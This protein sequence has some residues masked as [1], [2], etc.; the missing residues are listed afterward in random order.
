MKQLAPF[1]VTSDLLNELNTL[2]APSMLAAALRAAFTELGAAYPQHLTLAGFTGEFKEG[3]R[4]G[5]RVQLAIEEAAALA[6]ER[7]FNLYFSKGDT[8]GRVG[9][10]RL[11]FAPP[12][13]GRLLPYSISPAVA[14]GRTDR[15]L[16]R[17]TPAIATGEL[18]ADGQALLWM[19]GQ[20][21]RAYLK[22]LDEE[23][24]A[25]E[26]VALQDELATRHYGGILVHLYMAGWPTAGQ[27]LRCAVQ[28]QLPLARQPKPDRKLVCNGV[29]VAEH[30]DS[31][32]LLGT[33]AFT[34][35][36]MNAA[37]SSIYPEGA[38]E[39]R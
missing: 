32:E 7:A 5:D 33:F 30:E 2:A 19:A 20:S 11:R 36:R 28:Y 37:R 23:F 16:W 26:A 38:T 29:L 39:R 6:E 21:A 18:V 4:E 17:P 15:E 27:P 22:R 34:V 9:S 1:I 35:V 12:A 13:G 14:D 10:W 24:A 3:A 31:A 8:F 25:R